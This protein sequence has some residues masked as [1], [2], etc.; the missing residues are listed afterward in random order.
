MPEQS[1]GGFASV[2]S[3]P[4]AAQRRIEQWAQGFADKAQRYQAMRDATE[5]IRLTA[6]S[7]NGRVRVTVRADGSVTDLELTDKIRTMPPAEI[8]AQILATMRKAQGDIASQVG[9]V[10]A[11]H[12]GDEDVRTRSMMT[13]RLREQFP[14]EPDE[15]A[16]GSEAS[17]KWDAP[18]E[19]PADP[20]DSGQG[21]P[22][23]APE[24]HAPA[25][26]SSVPKPPASNPRRPGTDD[27]FDENDFDEGFDPLRD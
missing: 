15:S 26:G 3:D 6:A 4:D 20:A 21:K 19:D 5:Q 13:D 16:T 1:Q 24:S 7:P 18:E 22:K 12:L 8:S 14:E 27:G 25:P 10:M 17:G 2:G 11:E 23:P 9:A